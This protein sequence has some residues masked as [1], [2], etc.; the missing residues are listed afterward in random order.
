MAPSPGADTELSDSDREKAVKAKM[1]ADEQHKT[2]RLTVDAFASK[3]VI[4]FRA[5]SNTQDPSQ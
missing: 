4:T 1:G 2:A 3:N 5:L